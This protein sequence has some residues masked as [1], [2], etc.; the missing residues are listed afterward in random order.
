MTQIILDASVAVKWLS[1]EPLT[2]KAFE[3][4]SEFD[5]GAIKMIVPELFF[6]ELGNFCVGKFKKD[7]SSWDIM[8]KQLEEIAELPF[9]KRSDF[10]LHDV[11]VS[12]ACIYGISAYDGV[13]LS[14]AEMYNAPLIT[15]DEALL[16]ACQGRFDFIEHLKDFKI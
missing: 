12:N 8:T 1:Q 3:L 11:A 16:K 6:L 15:V 2:E 7:S 4:Y 5:K 13:Y 14:L 9:E 10:E